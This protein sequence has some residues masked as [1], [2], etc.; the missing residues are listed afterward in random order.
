MVIQGHAHTIIMQ[1]LKTGLIL[2]WKH[3]INHYSGIPWA[4]QYVYL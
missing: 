3:S 1:M 2:I 4:V